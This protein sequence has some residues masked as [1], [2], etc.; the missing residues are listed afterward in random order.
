MYISI[1][2]HMVAETFRKSVAFCWRPHVRGCLKV[3]PTVEGTWSARAAESPA[4]T[5]VD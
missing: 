1:L 2:E 4:A 5:L 3:G